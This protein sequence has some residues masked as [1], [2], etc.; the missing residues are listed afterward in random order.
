MLAGPNGLGNGGWG[1]S[2]IADVLPAR[3]PP[4]TAD[5]FHRKK[6]A[7]ALT[8][9][10]VTSQMMRFDA[11]DDA[12]REA[13]LE[14][15]E[16]ADYQLVGSLKPAAITLL[17]AETDVGRV[18]L[19][20]TQPFGRGHAYILASGGTWR[21]Q[22]SMPLEDQKH[23][24]FWR[25]LL[26]ALVAS[27]PESVSLTASGGE[28]DDTISLRAEFRDDAFKPVDDIAVTAIA[29]HEDGESFSLTMQ[30]GGE[31]AGVF[32]A[33]MTPPRS[34]TWYFEAVAEKNGEPVA[35]S[36]SSILHESGQSEYFNF[37]KNAAL[38]QRLSEATGGR[39]FEPDD[40]T[41]LPDLLSYA[42]SGITETEYR[43]IW[44]A[45]AVFILLLLL[46]AG[47]WLLRRRWSSI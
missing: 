18:P 3:L 27:A 14:L 16:V 46:K 10:G 25:Q 8:P 37:R 28:K 9:Q 44:D 15:P 42:S 26:R 21:W 13:W 40:L 33:Q 31:E 41:G 7:V 23:E 2:A 32:T 19:L 45:P 35:V 20:M 29:S 22:M 30:A 36:R 4:T 24:T 38:L 43:A 17:D 11:Q 47:E 39:Y 5:S 6:A 12:N 34:G 1:Q